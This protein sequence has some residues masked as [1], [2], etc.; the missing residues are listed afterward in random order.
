MR[1]DELPNGALPESAACAQGAPSSQ[2]HAGR[3]FGFVSAPGRP[4]NDTVQ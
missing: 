4:Q 2:S 1:S 3:R